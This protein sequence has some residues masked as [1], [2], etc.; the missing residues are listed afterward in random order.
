MD[1]VRRKSILVTIQVTIGTI[2]SIQVT[3][4]LKGKRPHFRL[5]CVAQRCL[6]SLLK[7]KKGKALTDGPC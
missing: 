1:I 5:A 4:G 3:I 6:S 2:G 7:H